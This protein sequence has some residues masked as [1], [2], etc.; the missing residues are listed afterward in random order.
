MLLVNKLIEM[1]Q[2]I[3][4]SEAIFQT[5]RELTGVGRKPR[6]SDDIRLE[7]NL[8]ISFMLVRQKRTQILSFRFVLTVKL[9]FHLLT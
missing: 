3:N 5:I 8:L 2:G 7:R 1:S 6:T 9:D 4:T